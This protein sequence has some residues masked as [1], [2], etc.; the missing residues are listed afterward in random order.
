VQELG[1]VNVRRASL[2]LASAAVLTVGL[3]SVQS[4]RSEAARSLTQVES[5]AA[6]ARAR[7]QVLTSEVSQYS[8]RI[9]TVEARLAPIQARLNELTAELDRLR[10]RRKQLTVEIDAEQKRLTGLVTKLRR[11]R[12]ALADRLSSAYRR[13]DPSVIQ[14]LVQSVSLSTAISAKENL[15][16]TVGQDGKLIDET[17]AGANASL[18]ARNAIQAK[19]REVWQNEKRVA[20]AEAEMRVTVTRVTAERNNLVSARQARATLLS[21]V[22]GDRRELEAEARNLRARSIRLA[23]QIRTQSASLPSAVPVS[24]NGTFAWP[25]QG[26]VVSGFGPRWGRMHEGIDIAVGTGVPIGAS[27]D[28]TVIVAGWT[29]GYGQLVVVSHG[30]LSTAYAHMSQVNVSVGQRVSRG[31]TL[32]AVGCTGHCYGPHVHYEVRVNGAAVNPIPYM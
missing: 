4:E 14:I 12:A 3:T 7:E 1:S 16:R 30:T 8:A 23:N 15:E 27:A 26:P 9:R 22:K 5:Q 32:G 19:R 17:R 29:G 28:G 10:D 11:H 21:R 20:E 31:Q 25:V 13:G 2:A 18:H 6:K 24:G